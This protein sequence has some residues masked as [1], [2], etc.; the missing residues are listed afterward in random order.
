MKIYSSQQ[1]S[2]IPWPNT[3]E[4]QHLKNLIEPQL[5]YGTDHFISNVD[6]QLFILHINDCFIPVSVNE[7]EYSN[8]Y[9]CSLYSY[10]SYAEEEMDRHH[11]F[12]LKTLLSPLLTIVKYAFKLCKINKV[13]IVN[14]FFFSTNLF[15]SLTDDEL[16]KIHLFLLKTFPNHA[17]LFRSLNN[18]FEKKI[19]N[20]LDKLNYNFITSRSIYIF[21]PHHLRHLSSKKRWI[22]QKDHKLIFQNSITIINEDDFTK[23]DA[24]KVKDLYDQLYLKKYSSLNPNFT[25][26]FFK[27]M[28][29]TKTISLKGI[30]F[31]DKLVAV[32]GYFKKKGIIATPIVGYEIDLLEKLGLYRILTA[33][34][35]QE[36]INTDCPFHMSA[37][38]GHFKRQRGAFQELESMAVYIKHL[39]LYRRLLWLSL[40][41]LF[42]KIGAPI[43]KKQ[44]L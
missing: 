16:K 33:L 23:A 15:D 37:G 32:I 20:Y 3:I 7:K 42:N 18:Y 12:I 39:P 21:D 11:K 10:L 19:I 28:I 43:L 29:E 13:A 36:S 30:L 6:S 38:V 22:I 9:V 40:S 17:I 5:R 2:E 4:G 34:I 31:R 8:S 44:K 26:D 14:N 41:F 35:L 24:S 1:W 25:I 27:K